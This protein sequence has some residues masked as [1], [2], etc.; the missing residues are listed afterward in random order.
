MK[1][2]GLRAAIL[3]LGIVLAVAHYFYVRA[4]F[5]SVAIGGYFLVSTILFFLG[6]ATGSLASGKVFRA[7]NVGLILLSLVDC[8]LIIWTRTF[9]TVFFQGRI[10]YWSTGWMPPGAVQIFVL[11]VLMILVSGYALLRKQGS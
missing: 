8:L 2:N 5:F 4:I 1:F 3:V 7:A 11:Q 6:A 10:V 9:P